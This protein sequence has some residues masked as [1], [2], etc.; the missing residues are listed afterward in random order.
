MHV[1]VT[2]FCFHINQPFASQEIPVE[3]LRAFILS[4]SFKH[5]LTMHVEDTLA[6]L[7]PAFE[8]SLHYTQ[9][10]PAL[11][12]TGNIWGNDVHYTNDLPHAAAGQK[13]S[14]PDS[15]PLGD[16]HNSAG[17]RDA[18]RRPSRL[19]SRGPPLRA[20]MISSI[21]SH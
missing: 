19:A 16:V 12:G 10:K 15:E 4:S 2:L 20:E 9:F 7:S 3:S 8:T 1:T 14:V 5:G 17:K 11:H 13:E 21:H 18:R 6:V